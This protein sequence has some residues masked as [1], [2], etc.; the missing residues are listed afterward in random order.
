LSSAALSPFRSPHFAPVRL[1]DFALAVVLGGGMLAAELVDLRSCLAAD[2]DLETGPDIVARL[3]VTFA[4]AGSADCLRRM[5]VS[6][7]DGGDGANWGSFGGGLGGNAAAVAGQK[8]A[9]R[10]PI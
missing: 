10:W 7:G 9:P 4:A 3:A 1:G 6:T 2:V 5:P 8:K